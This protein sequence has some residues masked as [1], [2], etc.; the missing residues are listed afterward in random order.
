MG[1]Q[2]RRSVCSFLVL[3]LVG[4]TSPAVNKG[5]GATV[6]GGG[7]PGS[8]VTGSNGGDRGSSDGSSM[9]GSGGNGT[10]T[11]GGGGGGSSGS[12]GSSGAE[13]GGGPG[14]GG[15]SGG[16]G[17]NNAGGNNAGGNGSAGMDAGGPMSG[18][19]LDA[20]N[21]GASGR[22]LAFPGAEGFGKYAQGG[23]GGDVYH[24][25]S[26][27]DS[28][29]GS[30]RDGVT[31]ATGPRTIVFD[32]SGTIALGSDL[33]ITGKSNMT[34]AG[35]TAPG[36]GITLR[37]HAIFIDA[38]SHIVV[39]YIRSRMGDTEGIESDAASVTNSSNII[40]DHCSLSW[41]VDSVFDLTKFTGLATV[42]WCILSEALNNS[43]HSK[44]PHS[45]AAGWD[46]KGAGGASY[47]HNLLAS[48]NSRMPRVDGIDPMGLPGPLVDIRNNV[49]YN[50]G[51]GFAYGGEFANMNFV[52]NY[53]KPGP[54]S[55]R[56]GW[57]F[58]VS[59]P[60]GRIFVSGNFVD[61][62]PGI[63]ADNAT[64]VNIGVVTTAF[65]V[66]SV[67]DETAAAAYEAV[68]ASV[69]ASRVRDAVDVRVI[70]DVRNR[71]GRI[72][73]SQ[74]D[75]GGWPTLQSAPPPPDTDGDGMPDSWETSHGLD[76]RNAADG[77][78]DGN[79]DGYTNLEEYL[80]S[81]ARP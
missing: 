50:W 30:F 9:G 63:T 17:G 49:I 10:G 77:K 48:C 75:V 80:N 1:L 29:G 4:C 43:V 28:G 12:A 65:P 69:G 54:S 39:R 35:Q 61:G 20:G 66:V 68:L 44:G 42:Q 64:G 74:N 14:T 62:Q 73:D 27:A 67:P 33:Q 51:S 40:F 59:G 57:L 3:V 31:T 36:D 46:G 34:I 22:V 72:I 2:S 53:L 23:R 55:T 76:P 15:G 26:L 41:S 16:T 70:A 18:V 78:G 52:D 21:D 24:V 37:N 60:A 25:T 81:L 45:Y 5:G 7:T 38:S 32:V 58:E 8:N 79:R 11:E 56:L 71:T 13:G 19:R 47:H 6:G